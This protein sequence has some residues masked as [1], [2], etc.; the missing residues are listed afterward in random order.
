[1]TPETFNER[2]RIYKYDRLILGAVL[3]LIG[4]IV[5]IF[6]FYLARF[7]DHSPVAFINMLKA[8][9]LLSPMLSLGCV[10]NLFI[11]FLLLRFNHNNA[12]RGVVLATLVYIIPV[13]YTKFF[14]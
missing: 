9:V 8:P 2:N 4:P 3:G 7:S 5:G 6:L 10:A 12:A 13:V 1:M 11:F 14:L